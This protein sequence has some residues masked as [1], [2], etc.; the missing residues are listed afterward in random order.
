MKRL[1]YRKVIFLFHEVNS[2]STFYTVMFEFSE[3][4]GNNRGAKLSQDEF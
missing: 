1:V 2:L 3:Y 4:D